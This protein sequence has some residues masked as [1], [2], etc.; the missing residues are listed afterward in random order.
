[1][2]ICEGLQCI[3]KPGRNLLFRLRNSHQRLDVDEG[4]PKNYI[5][6]KA[7]L[8]CGRM[9]S[10]NMRFG[11]WSWSMIH[12]WVNNHGLSGN[13]VLWEFVFPFQNLGMSAFLASAAGRIEPKEIP[14]VA[15]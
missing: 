12:T 13:E 8:A 6:L 14:T 3:L 10:M 5:E 9:L 7:V 11:N 15:T 2:Y 4:L 1:M